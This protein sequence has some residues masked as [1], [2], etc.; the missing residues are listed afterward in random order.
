[1]VSFIDLNIPTR[2]QGNPLG[3]G[4]FFCQVYGMKLLTTPME[5][6][7]FLFEDS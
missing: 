1:M 7:S 4:N 5:A 6:I 2:N 3:R